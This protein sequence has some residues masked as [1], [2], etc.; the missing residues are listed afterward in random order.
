MPTNNIAPVNTPAVGDDFGLG[1]LTTALDNQQTLQIDRQKQQVIQQMRTNQA[2]QDLAK[3]SSK[4][5]EISQG[6]SDSMGE[7]T[8]VLG[9]NEKARGEMHSLLS[10][11]N[12]GDFVSAIGKQI[13]DPSLYTRKGREAREQEVQQAASAQTQIAGVK[14]AAL[15]DAGNLVKANLDA[16]AGNL[17]V[18]QMMEQQGAERIKTE[19]DKT[20]I[21]AQQLA[22][23][24]S[25]QQQQLALMSA[26][27]TRVALANSGGKPVNVGGVLLSP[28]ALEERVTLLDQRKDLE[29][30]RQ[31][32]ADLKQ[33]DAA[34]R[35]SKQILSTYSLEEL[36]PLLLSGDPTGKFKLEDIKSAYD[37]KNQAMVDSVTRATQQ[38]SMADFGQTTLAPAGQT[39]QQMEPNMP[40][41]GPLADAFRQYKNTSFAV[42][43]TSAQY[44]NPA[45]GDYNSMPLEFHV[46][47]TTAIDKAKERLNTAIGQQATIQAKGDAN[48]KEIYTNFYQG[49]PIPKASV[50]AAV[51]ERL[52]KQQPLDDILPP[53]VSQKVRTKYNT[54]FAAALQQAGQFGGAVSSENRKIIQNQAM[55][56]AFK[57]SVDETIGA[58]TNDVLAGQV[59]QAGNPLNGVMSPPEFLQL[60]AKSDQQGLATFQK[61]YKLSDAEMVTVTSGGLVPDKGVDK[62]AVS[63][64]API[65]NQAMFLNLDGIR[66]G[67]AKQYSDWWTGPTGQ[68]YMTDLATFRSQTAAKSGIQATSFESYASEREQQQATDMIGQIGHAYTDGYT[69]HKQEAYN[70]MVSFGQNP[71]YRQAALL[72]FDPGLNDGERKQ[73]YTGFI[74]PILDEVN[75]AGG[76]YTQANQAVEAAINSGQSSDPNQ[77]KLLKKIAVNRST[78]TSQLDSIQVQPFWQSMNPFGVGNTKSADQNLLIKGVQQRDYKWFEDA[79][80]QDVPAAPAST[81][82]SPMGNWVKAHLPG[83]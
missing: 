36:R 39:I 22:A 3:I 23:A 13:M 72:Q 10:S 43:N 68:K 60:V 8:S 79:S 4:S 65:Q 44:K 76:T 66:N 73:F 58:R 52:D 50:E 34:Q 31:A 15:Q 20:Q 6:L 82:L 14:Q 57:E 33:L 9:E 40:Q 54:K 80:Q 71:S 7:L 51:N 5:A 77:L 25:A 45:T 61:Q 64:L 49:N 26:D 35:L 46:V 11:G 18:A 62:A 70:H 41:S 74:K 59:S 69:E 83:Q 56:D 17:N 67:L 37:I 81:P 47:G 53:D 29:A 1:S 30:G 42:A 24:N 21:Q 78:T 2:Q 38:A 12:P 48:M 27:Q 16:S 63:T 55:Q 32:T 19:V 28:G 75:K